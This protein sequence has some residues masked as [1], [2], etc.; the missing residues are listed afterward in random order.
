MLKLVRRARSSPRSLA[1][2]A[3]AALSTGVVSH[4]QRDAQARARPCQLGNKAGQIKHVIYL[5]FDN[6]HFRRDDA[7]R[8]VGSRADAAPAQLPQGQRHALHER[9]HDPDLA[10]RGRDP[11]VADRPLPGPQRADGLEQLRLLRR[12]T[13]T[14]RFT[15]SFKYWTDTVDGDERRRCRT[16]SAT[17]ARPRRRRGLTYTQ[18]GCNVGGVSAA[19]IELENNSTAASGD[20]TRVFGVGLA[21]VERGERGDADSSRRP[22]SS[23]SRSTARRA[24]ALCDDEPEREAGRLPTIVP[25]LA[26]TASRRSS[27]R[28]TSNPAITGGQPCVKATGRQ[29][30][31]TDPA[32]NCG[33]PGF[34]GTLAKNTLGD[35]AQMQEN[36]VPVTYAYISDAHDNHTLRPRVSGPGE[37]DY[38]AAARRLRR[39]VRRRSS[40]RLAAATASTR[41]TRSSSSRSTRATTSPAASARRSPDGS[42]ALTYTHT[43]CTDRRPRARRTRSA[44][45]TRT[46]SGARA[47]RQPTFDIHF[48]DAPTFYVNGQPDADRPD[49]AQARAG[50]SARL[51]CPTR[52]SH[53][54][55]PR[56]SRSASPTRSRRRRC[57]WSTPIRSG[58]RRSRCSANADFF[59][60]TSNC[61]GWHRSGRRPS[62][63]TRGSPGTTATSRTRSATRGSGWS[64]PASTANGDRLEDLD[65][66]RRPPAD[67]QRARS[68]C[69]TTTPTTA[70]SS[71]RCSTTSAITDRRSTATR[72]DAARRAYKQLNAPF[73]A[74]R[75]TTRSSRRPRRSRSTDE[76]KYD[77]IETQIA[78]LTVQARRA[79]GRRSAQRSTTRRRAATRSTTTRRTTGSSRRRA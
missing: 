75:G 9:P 12:A 53:A 78:N 60:Q 50:S 5:Q 43:T 49:G 62:A 20:M 58:R 61:A 66:P 41:A 63:S 40:Q 52:T 51:R 15:S 21:R 45:S 6:T 70:V 35:V 57:T 42:G 16:W 13:G 8:R 25:G 31:I 55:S 19:N 10:H 26:T 28:S 46:S 64:A 2:C 24:R 59:F 73:G 4:R 56:R 74:V 36:G 7:E 32:G 68:G 30:T 48:D 34:D 22:T 77:S 39:G 18:A 33:F 11:R 37:A 17:A 69:R 47:D 3:A 67:D 44:R 29:P 72:V 38:Q 65:G 54:A 71:R 79:R 1:A 27:A 14:P 23:A 76:L